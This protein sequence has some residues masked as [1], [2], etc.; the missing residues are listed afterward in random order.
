MS[1]KIIKI[2]ITPATI[3]P[4]YELAGPKIVIRLFERSIKL[5]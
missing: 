2:R 4:L 1:P 3:Y 5:V